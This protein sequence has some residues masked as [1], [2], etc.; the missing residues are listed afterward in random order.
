MILEK[1]S[2]YRNIVIIAI[3]AILSLL[4]YLNLNGLNAFQTGSVWI[5]FLINIL[6][7][8]L[9]L[10]L[11]GIDLITLFLICVNA[12]LIPI[13]IQYFTGSSYGLLALNIVPL[14]LSSIYAYNFIYCACVL[15]VSCIT[16]FK[17]NEIDLFS[18][19]KIYFSGE[20]VIL[21]NNIIALI[22]TIVAFPRIGLTDAQNRFNMLLP[23]RAWNQ[24]VIVA[25]LFNV[26]YLKTKRSVQL[27]YLFVISWFLI[28]GE[29]A[30]IT[31]LFL[32]LVVFYFLNLK[33]N[34][35]NFGIKKKLKIF[36]L[37]LLVIIL[38][39]LIAILRNGNEV[40]PLKAIT[41]L[42]VT[43][44]TADVGYLYNV[45]IDSYGKF[46]AYNGKIFI[47]NLLSAIP[48]FSPEGFSDFIDLEHYANPGGEPIIAEPIM[49]FG[50]Y[51]VPVIAIIDTL[52]FRL[53]VQF[54][55]KFFEF[56]L[57]LI[58]CTIPRVVWYG[59]SYSYTGILF[60]VPLMF[61][62]NKFISV[63]FK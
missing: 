14:H 44:T 18:R 12:L 28:D 1:K 32:G 17:K 63:H 58:L 43:P 5:A 16:S 25:L 55:N 50:I 57:L 39:N 49:D 59:R 31:G 47:S 46:G 62:A 38:M 26:H 10:Y 36:S 9:S 54:K 20:T 21:F 33:I 34:K 51:G 24:L 27:T 40:T 6:L 15:L 3:I 35:I 7:V 13:T 41:S 52:F 30:D 29:R 60:F 22:F 4:F 37:V 48:L 42:L 19:G 56:E 53:F 61:I 23:G 45:A 8:V 11:S 2:F